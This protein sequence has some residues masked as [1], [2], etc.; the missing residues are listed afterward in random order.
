MTPEQKQ[1][2][3]KRIQQTSQDLADFLQKMKQVFG[4]YELKSV[5][6]KE[7]K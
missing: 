4:P 5:K 7:G 6:W 1:R 2:E 3:W